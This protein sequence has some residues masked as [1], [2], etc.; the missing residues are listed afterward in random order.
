LRSAQFRGGVRLHLVEVEGDQFFAAQAGGEQDKDESPVTPRSPPGMD[1]GVLALPAAA[2]F[3]GH[4]WQTVT[5]TLERAHLRVGE[6]PRFERRQAELANTFGR[7]AEGEQP[8]RVGA[9]PGREGRERGKM[10]VH[11]RRRQPFLCQVLLPGDDVA[12][13]TAAHPVVAVGSLVEADEAAELQGDF[14][15]H[16]CGA[17]AGNGELLVALGPYRQ[18]VDGCR[19]SVRDESHRPV[20]TF[21]K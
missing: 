1:S 18:T 17:H 9:D 10:I 19:S 4:L 12:L 6:R 13:E 3:H 20:I 21:V 15:R 7:V 11:R 16:F 14:L 5:E 8:R 2:T